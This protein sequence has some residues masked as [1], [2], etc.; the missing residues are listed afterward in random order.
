MTG[1]ERGAQL[2]TLYFAILAAGLMLEQL[3]FAPRVKWS[4]RT[5]A[6]CFVVC[7]GS[8]VG[9]F[10]WFRNA[11]FG[12][13]GPLLFSLSVSIVDEGTNRAHRGPQVAAVAE[14]LEHVRLARARPMASE[15]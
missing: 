3:L 7:A 12:F 15:D 2:P 1:P 8:I 11:A 14:Q 13:D 9:T 4:Q 6:A 10:W 5:K